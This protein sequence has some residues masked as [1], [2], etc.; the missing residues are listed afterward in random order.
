MLTATLTSRPRRWQGPG[1]SGGFGWVRNPYSHRAF[2]FGWM[3]LDS[4]GML[5]AM[6]T[7]GV[8]K[9]LCFDRSAQEAPRTEPGVC[10]SVPMARRIRAPYLVGVGC[11]AEACSGGASSEVGRA[12]AAAGRFR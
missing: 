2:A 10:G 9:R 3:R 4:D 6:L 12:G 11:R 8:Q 7:S 1:D 5:T